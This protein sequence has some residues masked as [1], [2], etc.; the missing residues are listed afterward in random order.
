MIYNIK[1]NEQSLKGGHVIGKDLT[2]LLQ[3]FLLDADG[4]HILHVE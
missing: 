2:L 4:K 3:L 1:L